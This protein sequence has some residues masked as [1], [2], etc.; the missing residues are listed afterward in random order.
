MVPHTEGGMTYLYRRIKK[1]C[2]FQSEN[3][4]LSDAKRFCT[5]GYATRYEESNQKKYFHI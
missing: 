1:S 4:W 2:N 3:G 5:F